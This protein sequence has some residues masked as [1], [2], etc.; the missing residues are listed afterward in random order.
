MDPF[1]YQKMAKRTE[2]NQH[3]SAIRIAK[4][5]I[6]AVRML[7]AAIGLSSDA[8]EVSAAIERWIFYGQE[9]DRL[10]LIEELGDCL[11][12]I[13]Q[14]CNALDIDMGNVMAT[15]LG[16]LERRYPDK[17]NADKSEEVNRDRASE[18]EAIATCC[19][20]LETCTTCG[21]DERVTE[22]DNIPTGLKYICSGHICP[23]CSNPI[24]DEVV[25]RLY[26]ERT[27]AEGCP[28]CGKRFGM[29]LQ[30]RQ[31]F[32]IEETYGH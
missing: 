25:K 22:G 28:Q 29:Q 19:S 4:E 1:R 6:P 31:L 5:G 21:T 18:R 14:M 16:K 30:Q 12:Y 7:H 8:G 24:S 13:A 3:E 2:C 10:N 11:W 9:L 26:L 15:N 20:D 17:F 32:R 23:H 27:T